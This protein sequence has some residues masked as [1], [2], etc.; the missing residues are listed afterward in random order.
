MEQTISVRSDRNVWHHLWRWSTLTGLVISVDKIVVPSTALLNPVYKNN[1]QTRGGLGRVC[2]TGMYRSIGHVVCYTAVL[3]VVEQPSGALHDDTKNGCVADY[4]H[5]EFQISKF[6]NRNFFWMESAWGS[7]AAIWLL[8][9][10]YVRSRSHPYR[11]WSS[12][13][14]RKQADL[15]NVSAGYERNCW[16]CLE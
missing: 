7:F 4:W 11:L 13:Q 8:L 16:N 2:A 6:R 5:V 9:V 14:M 1:T 3:R 12:L 10:L 15:R